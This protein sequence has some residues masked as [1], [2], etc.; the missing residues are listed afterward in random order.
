MTNDICVHF[1]FS[2]GWSFDGNFSDQSPSGISGATSSGGCIGVNSVLNSALASHRIDR[3][4]GRFQWLNAGWLAR[5]TNPFYLLAYCC[6]T[7]RP[8]RRPLLSV[9]NR[10]L[11]PP[12][13]CLFSAI[14]PTRIYNW[15]VLPGGQICGLDPYGE[16]LEEESRTY[17]R[18]VALTALAVVLS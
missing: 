2:G 7:G 5:S 8:D 15:A 11:L 12:S 17:L 9:L 10:F 6:S 16:V 3:S 13:L 14:S 1:S 4:V 18:N